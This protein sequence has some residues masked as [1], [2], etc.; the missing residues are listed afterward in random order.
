MPLTAREMTELKKIV[1]RAQELIEKAN[2]TEKAKPAPPREGTSKRRRTGKD[3]TVFRRQ[4]K[5]E[6]KA[7]VPVAEIAAKHG[8]SRAYIYQLG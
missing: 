4:L 6:R 1:F 7:G 5:A 8:V 3:L 2:P